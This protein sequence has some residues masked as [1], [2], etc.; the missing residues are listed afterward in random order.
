MKEFK[1]ATSES[2]VKK[3]DEVKT[4]Q[5]YLGPEAKSKCGD[6]YPDLD[7]ALEALTEYYGNSSLIWAKTRDEFQAS[8]AHGAQ[9]WGEYGDPAHVSAITRVIEFLQQCNHLSTEFS[10]LK[11]D[12]F[13]TSTFTLIRKI[14]LRDYMEKVNDTIIDV[15][16]SPEQKMLMIKRFLED[17]KTS[18]LMGVNT[19]KGSGKPKDSENQSKPKFNPLGHRN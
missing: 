14:L 8:F 18:A 15:T 19:S 12:I 5:K 13:S 16:A 3:A 2:Q 7:S 17:T 4:L 11:A 1:E 6:H 10:E 9:V